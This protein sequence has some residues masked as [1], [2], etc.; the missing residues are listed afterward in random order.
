MNSQT[1]V[2]IVIPTLNEAAALP[3]LL[4]A[5]AGEAA[6]EIIVVDGGSSDGTPAL[7]ASAG[8]RIIATPPC[9]GRQLAAGAA[10][11]QGDVLLFLHADSLFPEGGIAAIRRAL[12]GDPALVGGNFTLHFDGGTR[13]DAWLTGFYAWIRRHGL[14]YGDS[15]VFVRRDAY[16]RLGGI[17][18]LSVLEDYNFT[19]RLERFGRTC[20]IATP[21]LVT[22]SRRFAGRSPAA[23]V[24][25]WLLI[26]LLY[27]LKAPD[28]VL[29]WVYDSTR[30]GQR[31]PAQ[32]AAKPFSAQS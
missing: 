19:R 15:G 7:A 25:G 24:A 27:Y 6:V 3:R 10:L 23:I 12:D 20:C 32:R 30:R 29:A 22:S 4:G 8:A 9:R 18:P 14:Y 13:F 17:R 5:L 16:E 28:R 26:H 11:A 31:A 2:S 1:I 21:P